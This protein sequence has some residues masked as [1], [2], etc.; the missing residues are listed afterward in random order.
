MTRISEARNSDSGAGNRPNKKEVVKIA[1]SQ[2]AV[3]KWQSENV[4]RFSL[5]LMLK[6]DADVIEKL[7]SVPN[8]QGYIKKLIREDIARNDK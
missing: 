2:K 3:D 8:K 1:Y 6:S 4:K 7:S 5:A